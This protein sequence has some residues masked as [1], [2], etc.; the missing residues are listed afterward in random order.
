MKKDKNKLLTILLV[1]TILIIIINAYLLVNNLSASKDLKNRNIQDGGLDLVNKRDIAQ[2]NIS[3]NPLSLVDYTKVFVSVKGTDILLENN[4][5]ILPIITNEYQAYSVEQGIK[6]RID[7]R[8]TT[9]DIITN[10]LQNFNVSLLQAKVVENKGLHYF[11]RTIYKQGDKILDVD[12]KASDAVALALR[13]NVPVYVK[14][15]LFKNLGQ[16]VC[17]SK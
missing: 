6:S 13:M 12:T 5:T 3:G 7:V 8:P 2:F 17:K 15:D 4:C 10:I 1:I 16:N 11:A 9:H 14:T